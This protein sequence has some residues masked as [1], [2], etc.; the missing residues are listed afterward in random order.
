MATHLL[1][2]LLLLALL[3]HLVSATTRS[4]E[5]L[6]L[7]P[8][9]GL[10]PETG[11]GESVIIGAVDTGVWPESLSFRDPRATSGVTHMARRVRCRR[12]F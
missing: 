11:F 9:C 5:F 6:K 7:S 10:W 1:S 8:A 12:P 4:P 2:F 3:P